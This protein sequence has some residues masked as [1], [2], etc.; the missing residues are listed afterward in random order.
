MRFLRIDHC[1]SKTDSEISFSF[2]IYDALHHT[3][4]W[5][6]CMTFHNP[7]C[8]ISFLYQQN[9]ADSKVCSWLKQCFAWFLLV[10]SFSIFQLKKYWNIAQAKIMQNPKHCFSYVWLKILQISRISLQHQACNLNAVTFCRH[11]I[12]FVFIVE[13]LILRLKL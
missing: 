2:L 4:L 12:S 9:V 10:W 7:Q 13:K 1:G 8:W 6:P 5:V 11:I 3:T